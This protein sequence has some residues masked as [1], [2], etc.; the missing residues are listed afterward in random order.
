MSCSL[1]AR[2]LLCQYTTCSCHLLTSPSM[3]VPLTLRATH[4]RRGRCPT[5]DRTCARPVRDRAGTGSMHPDLRRQ[6][7]RAHADHHAAVSTR[8]GDSWLHRSRFERRLLRRADSAA[9]RCWAARRHGARSA[10][11]DGTAP[12]RPARGAHRRVGIPGRQRRPDR[13]VRRHRREQSGDSPRRLDRTGS[14][15]R[16]FGARRRARA[17]RHGRQR[18]PARS[19]PTSR[20]CAGH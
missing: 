18:E 17:T 12:P 16:W 20:P 3:T 10:D 4:H 7:R 15:A 14:A 8:A 6:R 2:G 13:H 19:S 5:I 11:L 1:R 9:T